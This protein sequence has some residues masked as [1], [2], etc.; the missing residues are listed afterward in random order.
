MSSRYE[1]VQ[2]A[3]GQPVQPALGRRDGSPAG[4]QPQPVPTLPTP[5]ASPAT[6]RSVSGA[7]TE[8]VP[9]LFK[10]AVA[11]LAFLLRAAWSLSSGLVGF[12]FRLLVWLSPFLIWLATHYATWKIKRWLKTVDR[13]LVWPLRL[14]G[15]LA[16]GKAGLEAAARDPQHRQRILLWICLLLALYW[17]TLGW[18]DLPVLASTGMVVYLRFQQVARWV[19]RAAGLGRR[20]AG[21]SAR[22]KVT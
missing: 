13:L 4:D 5:K 1:V 8:S 14:L 16:A 22:A 12:A 6:K 7:L 19:R 9:R 2:G 21:G 10:P 17:L 20:T 11:L 15:L 3:S 18:V